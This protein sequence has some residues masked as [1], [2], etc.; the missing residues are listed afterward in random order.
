MIIFDREFT[1][2]TFHI[3]IAFASIETSRPSRHSEVNTNAYKPKLRP[4]QVL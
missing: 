4:E 3:C 1:M 2:C